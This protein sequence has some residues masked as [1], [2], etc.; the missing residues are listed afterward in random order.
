[1]ITY[2]EELNKCK[3]FSPSGGVDKPL[4]ALLFDS[5]FD[6]HKGVVCLVKVID[7]TIKGGKL[8]LM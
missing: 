2:C 6:P 8:I 3:S 7:G 1:M 4:K 5:W